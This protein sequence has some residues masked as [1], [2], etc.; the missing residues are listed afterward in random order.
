MEEELEISVWGIWSAG[1]RHY[2]G[3]GTF[4]LFLLLKES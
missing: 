1:G 4:L 2:L 3:K